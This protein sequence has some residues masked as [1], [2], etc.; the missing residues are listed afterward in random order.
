MRELKKKKKNPKP[1]QIEKMGMA[2]AVGFKKPQISALQN[3]SR[4][5]SVTLLN[6]SP[7][8]VFSSRT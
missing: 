2:A 4:S 6:L 8:I 3:Q 5:Q 1:L 7:I